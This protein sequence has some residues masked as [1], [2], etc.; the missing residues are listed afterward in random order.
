MKLQAAAL[1][2]CLGGAVGCAAAAS[3][4]DDGAAAG[5]SA[6]A[7]DRLLVV[8]SAY[9]ILGTARGFGRQAY[10]LHDFSS[11]YKLNAG[12]DSES[13]GDAD[14]T[15]ASISGAFIHNSTAASPH[16][17]VLSGE[18]HQGPGHDAAHSY[19]YQIVA[20]GVSYAI[21]PS[22]MM[23]LE[24]RYINVD[25]SQGQLPKLALVLAPNSHWNS[26]LSYAHSISGN[27]RTELVAA[28]ID[29]YRSDARMLA[30]VAFGTNSPAVVNLP[31][32]FA[33][34]GLNSREVYAGVARQLHAGELSLVT[35]V[36]DLGAS[37]RIT[38]TISYSA[39]L[40]R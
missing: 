2:G 25:T 27:L 8:G 9:D 16:Q 18:I 22:L 19:T 35:D 17:Y 24:D 28:R 13:V 38:L 32:T 20:A 33:T 23:Q 4:I 40:S 31:T 11:A 7:E 30:G 36:L 29:V 6:V 5:G 26:T 14:W 3:S 10:W 12:I 39:H 1:F 34:P 21:S 37:R 15:V